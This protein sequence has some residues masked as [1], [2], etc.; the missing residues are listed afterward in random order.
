MAMAYSDAVDRLMHSHA[1]G[2]VAGGFMSVIRYI[3]IWHWKRSAVAELSAL[4]DRT[5]KDMGLYRAGIPF[6]VQEA[7]DRGGWTSVRC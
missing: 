2:R 1:V 4:D 6:V 7:A 3:R 5:L